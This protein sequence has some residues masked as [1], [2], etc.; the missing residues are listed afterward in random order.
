MSNHKLQTLSS[1]CGY[2]LST[3]QIVL[4]MKYFF[5]IESYFLRFC[6]YT[7]EV[8]G[9]LII[10]I[11][12]IFPQFAVTIIGTHSIVNPI[13]INNTPRCSPSPLSS[14]PGQRM[15]ELEIGDDSKDEAYRRLI[16]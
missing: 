2:T 4:E 13:I 1:I 3:M 11:A 8:A 10:V 12:L 5:V 16:W 6:V 15:S 9:L 7:I 14:N